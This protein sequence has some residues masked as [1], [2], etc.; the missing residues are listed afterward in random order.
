MS[1]GESQQERLA[2]RSLGLGGESW[3]N[4]PEEI[5]DN[6]II[7][8][9]LRDE[10]LETEPSHEKAETVSLGPTKD[11]KGVQKDFKTDNMNAKKRAKHYDAKPHPEVAT[12]VKD[13]AIS[14]LK[15]AFGNSGFR[16]T[17]PDQ[18]YHHSVRKNW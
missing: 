13:M 18:G 2:K 1:T 17:V 7:L 15:K 11:E 5:K 12:N 4:G 16:S 3:Y 14:W 8:S 6:W 9:E 10:D